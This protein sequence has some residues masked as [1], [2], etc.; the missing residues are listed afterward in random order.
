MGK[1]RFLILR[2][3][4]PFFPATGPYRPDGMRTRRGCFSTAARM[5]EAAAT[6]TTTAKTAAPKAAPAVA[7]T[8]NTTTVTATITATEAAARVA[9]TIAVA[10]ETA[11]LTVAVSP[12]AAGTIGRC[13]MGRPKSTGWSIGPEAPVALLAHLAG[14]LLTTEIPGTSLTEGLSG[15]TGRPHMFPVPARRRLV[16][17]AVIRGKDLTT[18]ATGAC[19]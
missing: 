18:P 19:R 11:S 10:P 1:G 6:E 12:I 5:T 17:M 7:A 4:A 2:G 15:S 9:S 3:T 8:E 14:P 13:G 16:D